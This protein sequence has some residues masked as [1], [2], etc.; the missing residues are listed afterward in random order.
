[1]KRAS[2]RNITPQEPELIRYKASIQQSDIC[3]NNVSKYNHIS[4]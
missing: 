1:M 3:S 2:V 4:D